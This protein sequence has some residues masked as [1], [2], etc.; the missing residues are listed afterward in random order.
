MG[1]AAERRKQRSR[2]GGFA[3]IPR[4]VM[5]SDQYARLTFKAKALLIEFAFQYK[6]TNNGDLSCAQKLMKHRGFPARSTVSEACEELEEAGFIERTR[7]GGRN[8]CNLYALTW[9]PID[10]CRGK[11]DARP[12]NK[13]SNRWCRPPTDRGGKTSGMPENQATLARGSGKVDQET[14][15]SAA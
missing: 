7:Q 3:G 5:R 14:T 1:R 10:E 6:G 15:K 9:Q 8:Q 11:L 12:T 13:P 4:E 2:G